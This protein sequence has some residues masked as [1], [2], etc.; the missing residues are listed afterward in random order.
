MKKIKYLSLFSGIGGFELG[1]Q[2]SERYKFKNISFSEI[3][4]YATSVYTR[5][6]PKHQN[7]GN[8]ENIHT[9]DLPDFEL[10]VGGF[11][12]QA[13]SHAGLRKG[14]DDSRGTL[15]FE[16]SRILYDKRP[17]YFLL[18][19]VP[20]LLSHGKGKTFQT[21]LKI[22]SEMGYYVRWEI[23]NSKAFVPQNRER[24]F[25]KGYLGEE[26]GR[27]ILSSE[28]DCRETDAEVDYA[29]NSTDKQ[30]LVKLNDKAQAQTIYDSEGLATTL[31]A[32]GGGQGGKT[33]LYRVGVHTVNGV[34]LDDDTI[35]TTTTTGESF[36]LATK[37][38]QKPFDNKE[39]TYVIKKLNNTT[40]AQ[41]IYDETGISPCL[42]TMMGMH[43]MKIRTNT[44]KGYDNVT[45]GD[46]IRL[47]HKSSTNSRGRT[48]KN[49]TGALSCTSDWGTLDKDY[50][51]RR[52]TP[53]ECE[54][55]Q[56]FQDG[57]TEFG[58]NG[59]K[60]SDTQ[61]YKMTGN[62]VTVPVITYLIDNM[63][64]HI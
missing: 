57:W 29:W 36:A 38:R 56:G 30:K 2:K 64:M 28:G 48:Q 53:V 31:A 21:I 40:Q 20:G 11:P 52:L 22:L 59:E 9:E 35:A 16:I 34:A 58:V 26:C 63:E 54:R 6:F 12:C 37:K 42:D 39:D 32:N 13:F 8:A 3:D 45:T 60:I 15:F 43:P 10:L 18:E 23:H 33:G 19:N 25:I 44:T 5:H 51:I 49:S 50:R 24:I 46:G 47:D 41:S 4:K 14:F 61:R 62:A 7:L 1:M 27:E 17:K 55:L